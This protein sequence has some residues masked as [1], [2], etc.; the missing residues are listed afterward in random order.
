MNSKL[1][2]TVSEKLSLYY[3]VTLISIFLSGIFIPRLMAFLPGILGLLFFIFA[4]MSHKQ[5]LKIS[6]AEALFLGLVF[7]FALIS[8]LWAPN[9]EFA[10]ER[11]FK[12]L[13]IFTPGLLLIAVSRHIQWPQSSL[14]LKF[15]VGF[16]GIGIVFL[17]TEKLFN[18]QIISFLTGK[19]IFSFKLNRSYVVLSL[20]AVPAL[21][22]LTQMPMEKKK[23]ITLLTILSALFL[24]AFFITESQT[25]Q[26]CF[27]IGLFFLFVF[28]VKRKSLTKILMLSSVLFCLMVPFVIAP[29]KSSIPEDSLKSK[30][31]FINQTSIRYRLEIWNYAAET[32]LKSPIYGNGIE[33][34]RFMKS[35]TYMKNQRSY[36]ALHAHNSVLQIWAEFG[37]MG[38]FL[39]CAFIVYIFRKIENTENEN[40]RRLYLASFMTCFCCSLTGYGI[41]Q[42]W[43]LGLFFALAALTIAM[44]QYYKEKF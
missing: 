21:F 9:Q 11:S 35:D 36:N 41:W 42:S 17:I 16:L 3:L 2:F 33:A 1:S 22:F 38:I 40:V 15:L 27:I 10:V 20:F 31:Y 23:K 4:W 5:S 8:S 14:I 28:P 39:A 12:I 25:A 7:L 32:A 13:S 34:L 44:G 24:Y 29:I 19:E 6:K 18:H 37:L 30:N 43:Q 26:L